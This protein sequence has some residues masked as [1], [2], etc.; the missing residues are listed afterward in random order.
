M[1][2]D[3]YLRWDSMS[4]EDKEK[5]LTGFNIAAGKAGYLRASIGMAEENEV[6]RVLFPEQIWN[7]SEP[8]E[9]DFEGNM[10]AMRSVLVS[11]LAGQKIDV[12][13][14][15]AESTAMGRHVG[16]VLARTFGAENVVTPGMD[17]EDKKTWAESLVGF[18][19]LGA[20]LQKA[21]KRPGVWI[22][23]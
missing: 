22:S 16:E 3:V 6:L 11:Y 13:D 21:G 18:F 10:E 9:Y 8:V 15:I 14:R 4:E 5:Q 1:G 20:E 17:F 23:W 2:S 19:R 12:Q 7:S